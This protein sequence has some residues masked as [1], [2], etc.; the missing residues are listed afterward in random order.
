M[1]HVSPIK[2]LE[3]SLMVYGRYSQCKAIVETINEI[4]D[5]CEDNQISI[6]K[7]AVEI[8]TQTAYLMIRVVEVALRSHKKAL[9]IMNCISSAAQ[10]LKISIHAYI[11]AENRKITA[12]KMAEKTFDHFVEA[13]TNF[14]E[15]TPWATNAS[16]I[17]TIVVLNVI[18][19][20]KNVGLF[21]SIFHRNATVGA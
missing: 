10:L 19:I 9:L 4:K 5:T 1:N 3:N 13:V 2:I 11:H 14:L 7:K 17:F 18:K 20:A 6:R 16:L 8:S 12:Y 15:N 21:S